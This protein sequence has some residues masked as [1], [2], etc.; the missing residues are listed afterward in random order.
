MS[1][2]GNIEREMGQLSI[3][4]DI[5]RN[6]LEG[7]IVIRDPVNPYEANLPGAITEDVFGVVDELEGA[8]AGQAHPARFMR[9]GERRVRI[10]DNA[11]VT[12][13]AE[14]TASATDAGAAVTAIATGH[15]FARALEAIG[16]PT[17]D[18][19]I[20]CEIYADGPPSIV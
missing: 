3:P 18:Q 7:E 11:A 15:R 8:E 10:Q 16:A 14:L 20:I 19:F 2:L 17:T 1:Q 5:G 13:Y 12:L 6:L 4:S 9:R